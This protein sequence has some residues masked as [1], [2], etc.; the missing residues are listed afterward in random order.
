MRHVSNDTLDLIDKSRRARLDSLPEARE[1]R[2]QTLGSLRADKEYYVHSIC[3]R[4][5]HHLWS[6]DSRPAYRGIK[7]LGS[8]KPV[9]RICSVKASSGKLLTDEFEVKA[10]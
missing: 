8:S 10:C 1:L 9:S 7:A 4:V 2:R 6:S 3:E 5:K